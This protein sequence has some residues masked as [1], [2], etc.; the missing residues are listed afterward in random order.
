MSLW[1]C[2]AFFKDNI[3]SQKHVFSY[4]WSS[5]NCATSFW[6]RLSRC[7]TFPGWSF[8]FLQE[9]Q[10]SLGVWYGKSFVWHCLT[11]SAIVR[12]LL[13]YPGLYTLSS[14][15]QCQFLFI[16]LLECISKA[17]IYS[18]SSS[19]LLRHNCKNSSCFSTICFTS[20]FSIL[21]CSD[22]PH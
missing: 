6:R 15:W 18:P 20:L 9:T 8:Q 12:H 14:S 2:F 21:P 17:S 7:Q 13:W 4:I 1:I 16:D 3:Y 10:S 22:Y 11:Y 5:S 19:F